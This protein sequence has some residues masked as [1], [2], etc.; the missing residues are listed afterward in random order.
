[1][2]LINCEWRSESFIKVIRINII[3]HIVIDEITRGHSPGEY[4]ANESRRHNGEGSLLEE[5]DAGRERERHLKTG[6]RIYDNRELGNDLVMI[7]PEPERDPIV[8]AYD[9]IELMLGVRSFQF[10]KSLIGIRGARERELEIG[11]YHRGALIGDDTAHSE[12]MLRRGSSRI[13]LKRIDRAG[14]KPESI[15]VAKLRQ[16]THHH[17]MTDM[18]RVETTGKDAYLHSDKKRIIGRNL[19]KCYS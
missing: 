15:E 10:A 19:S 1:M 5:G 18:Y 4:R 7:S 14:H 17:G 9:K 6:T 12:T 3:D 8:R 11:D 13:N 16:I 2:I